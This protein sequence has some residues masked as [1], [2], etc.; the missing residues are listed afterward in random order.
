MRGRQHS[1]RLLVL[2]VAQDLR[3]AEDAH[4]DRDEIDSGVELAEAEGEARRA[5]IEILP[6]HPEQKPEHD[7]RQRLQDRAVRERDRGDEAEHD[8]REIFRR[9]E[10]QG[11]PRQRRRKEHQHQRGDCPGEEGA[12]RGCGERRTGPP[13]PRHL[14]A[15]DRSDRRRGLPREV[16]QDRGGRAAVLRAVIDAGEHDERRHRLEPEGDRKQ[17]R[18]R[19]GRADPR[20]HADHRAEKDP[21]E[22]P[23]QC[24]TG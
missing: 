15:V 5:G 6:D 11:R 24:S 16:D 14:V 20:Q 19:R 21:D 8:Q 2:E 10:L 3:D 23:E 22:A 12:E 9:P 17:H 7:H 13:L 18:D 1:A 4:R